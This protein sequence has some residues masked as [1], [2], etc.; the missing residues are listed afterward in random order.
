MMPFAEPKLPEIVPSRWRE[1]YYIEKREA[2]IM[3]ALRGGHTFEAA[4]RFAREHISDETLEQA[5]T[6]DSADISAWEDRRAKAQSSD[7]I[8]LRKIE[9]WEALIGI[10]VVALIVAAAFFAMG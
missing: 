7:Q 6:R 5:K 3:A 8:E 10:G 1:A 4:S 2:I 9:I